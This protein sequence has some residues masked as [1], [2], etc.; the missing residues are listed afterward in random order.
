MNRLVFDSMNKKELFS[1][2][3]SN[4]QR[5]VLNFLNQHDLFQRERVNRFHSALNKK[6]NLN[7]I[8]GFTISAFLSLKNLKRI[9][10]IRGPTF[11]RDF[12]S[13][14]SFSEEKVHFFIGL[15]KEDLIILRK[16]LPFL[17]KTYSYNPSFIVQSSFP[18]KEIKK[19][20][21]LINKSN[22]DFVWVCVG[23]PKQNIL[24]QDLFSLT[25]N[26]Y[27]FNVGA[28][29]DFILGKKKEAPLF[30][31]EIGIEWLYRLITDFKYSKKKVWRSF[32][33]L[34]YLN[35]VELKH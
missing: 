7:F 26:Q 6:N 11:T 23:S 20:A 30:F 4:K 12:L 2:L 28:A 8:D 32:V 33:G 16:K 15:N 18:R 25:D 22:S 19:I 35:K 27:Y 3:E 14:P 34:K 29:L 21:Q 9:P 10:R 13:I 17:K 1:Y 24:S 31:R 5:K